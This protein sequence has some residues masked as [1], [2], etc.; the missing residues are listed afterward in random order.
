[1]AKFKRSQVFIKRGFQVQLILKFVLLI[2][3]GSVISTS[4]LYFAASRDLSTSYFS[5]HQTIKSTGDLLLPSIILSNLVSILLIAAATVY[6]TLYISHKIAGPLFKIEKLMK[7]I[8]DGDLTVDCSLRGGDELVAL[9]EGME[10]MVQGLKE[11]IAKND[12][13]EFKLE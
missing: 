9:S 3:A 11:K 7:Q 5:A 10:K 2:L 6:V 8:G 4:I 12:P 1:M 13:S